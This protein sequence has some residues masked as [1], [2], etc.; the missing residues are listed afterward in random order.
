MKTY[1]IPGESLHCYG[2]EPPSAIAVRGRTETLSV[3]AVKS[4]EVYFPTSTLLLDILQI[5]GLHSVQLVVLIICFVHGV[6]LFDRELE[7]QTF[8]EHVRCK[9]V[10]CNQG[11]GLKCCLSPVSQTLCIDKL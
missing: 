8:V 9:F 7:D 11:G 4:V 10:G 2:L 3:R 6:K 1:L 5:V